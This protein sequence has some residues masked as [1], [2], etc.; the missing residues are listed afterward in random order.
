M[1]VFSMNMEYLPRENRDFGISQKAFVLAE[2]M[3]VKRT[4]P[5]LQLA[6]LFPVKS[7]FF[8]NIQTFDYSNQASVW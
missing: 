2:K 3:E 5:K 7:E 4:A 6:I 8:S 1:G